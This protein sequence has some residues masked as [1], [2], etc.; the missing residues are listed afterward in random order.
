MDSA[1]AAR[2]IAPAVHVGEKWADLGAG[3]GTFTTA[4][5][6]LVGPAGD[7]YAVDRERSAVAALRI[8][9]GENDPERARI[10]V[11]HA[12]F[13]QPLELPPV[14]GVLLA[15]ALHFVAADEQAPVLRCTAD[16]LGDT[17]AL[18]VVEYD[19]RAASRWV[20]FPVSLARLS[21]LARLAQLGAP[22]QIGRKRSMFGGTMYAAR[23][24]PA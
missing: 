15:N 8:I 24:S 14:D 17:G 3:T 4:I 9:E 13:T 22:E 7:V 18:I 19:N 5:A 1:D 2:L 20:P 12:D 6:R 21:D 11:I 23:L 10:V 16:L